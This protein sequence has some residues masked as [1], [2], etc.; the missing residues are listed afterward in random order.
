LANPAEVAAKFSAA[1]K[2][3]TASIL[4]AFN[5]EG[6]KSAETPSAILHGSQ[7]LAKQ[8]GASQLIVQTVGVVNPR[9]AEILLKQGFKQT[10]IKVGKETI[11]A[12]EKVYE[13]K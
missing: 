9:L 12:F 10:T 6:S 11:S 2:M 8:Q 1:G 4:G 7:A 13:V 3:L 5:A